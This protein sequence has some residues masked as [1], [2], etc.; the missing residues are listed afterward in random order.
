MQSN[1][2]SKA[3]T[4]GLLLALIT[5]VYQLV[6]TVIEPGTAIKL[7]LWVLKFSGSIWLLYFFIKEHSSLYDTF[8]Y[9][10]GFKFGFMI[11]L[12]SSVICAAYMFLHF[13][14]LFPDTVAEQMEAAMTMMQSSNPDAIDTLAKIED[15]LPQIIFVVILIYNT[16]FGI[17]ASSIIANYTKKGDIFTTSSAE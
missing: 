9:K 2:W 5:I 16:I 12:L 7:I 4:F 15:K 8:S 17:I 3:A 6:L 10:D 13:A 14:V 1:T 11:S